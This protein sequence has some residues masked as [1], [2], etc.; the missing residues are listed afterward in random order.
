VQVAAHGD[1]GGFLGAGE[2]ENGAAD[3]VN[4]AHAGFFRLS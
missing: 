2:I 4:V 1:Q 3:V